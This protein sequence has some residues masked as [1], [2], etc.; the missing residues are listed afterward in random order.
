MVIT[1][2]GAEK[3]K[4]TPLEADQRSRFA[5][6]REWFAVEAGL[7]NQ[8]SVIVLFIPKVIPE[9]CIAFA[10]KSRAEPRQ[11]SE[12]NGKPGNESCCQTDIHR[13][14]FR[15]DQDETNATTK[16]KTQ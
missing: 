6:R 2:S 4:I 13:P 14:S 10:S 12:G 3:R 9:S 5:V 7:G 1:H 8:W 16:H 15:Y 11:V